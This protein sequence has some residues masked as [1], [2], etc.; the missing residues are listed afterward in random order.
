M[1]FGKHID[2]DV[3][4]GLA[5]DIHGLVDMTLTYRQTHS[6]RVNGTF[7]KVYTTHSLHGGLCFSSVYLLRNKQHLHNISV[8]DIRFYIKTKIKTVKVKKATIRS[9]L[10]LLSFYFKK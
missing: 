7:S 8:I 6:R 9:I 10:D 3:Q 4:S 5:R 1:S 2:S